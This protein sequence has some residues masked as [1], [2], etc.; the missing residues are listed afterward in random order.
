M[1]SHTVVAHPRRAWRQRLC[2]LL[3][4]ELASAGCIDEVDAENA[5][6]SKLRSTPFDLVIAHHSL[7]PDITILPGNCSVLLVAQ[8]DETLFQ[9]VREHSI[10]AYL[11][12]NASEVLLLATLDLKPG[13]F[14]IDPA[15]A[16]WAFDEAAHHAEALS[17]LDALT[18]QE[19]VILALQEEGRS[20]LEI[21]GQLCI[22]KSTVKRHSAAISKKRKLLRMS[23]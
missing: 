9:A 19:Q 4:Q 8:W 11:S 14:L 10:L 16:C 13:E 20:L 21:A 6:E 7:A 17:L 22:A 23:K 18:P 12:E 2:W 3:A 5:L 1:H 15:F